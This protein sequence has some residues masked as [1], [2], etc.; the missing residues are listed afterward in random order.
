MV[1]YGRLGG[2]SNTNNYNMNTEL[3]Q[4][5]WGTE[6]YFVTDGYIGWKTRTDPDMMVRAGNV[7]ELYTTPFVEYL[8]GEWDAD[9]KMVVLN[10][11]NEDGE[12]ITVESPTQW[13]CV[14][15]AAKN[16]LYQLAS[17]SAQENGDKTGYNFSGSANGKNLVKEDSRASNGH[18]ISGLFYRG[19]YL[20]F[21]ITADKADDNA[22]LNLVLGCEYGDISL[23][24]AKYQ[25]SIRRMPLL[26]MVDRL[27]WKLKGKVTTASYKF[28]CR[29]V[30]LGQL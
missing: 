13:Y 22:S 19:A 1:G 10:T 25:V 6:A 16:M 24:A 4:N 18:Y 15:T 3:Y 21:I 2:W 26:F 5:Q 17:T 29:H 30:K 11:K 20:E 27:P 12:A 28:L 7:V 8:S 14:R 9:K 23:T